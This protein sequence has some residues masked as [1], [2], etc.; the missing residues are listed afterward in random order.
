MESE[1]NYNFNLFRPRNRHGVKN[2]NIILSMLVVWF[3]AVF[4]FQI[5]LKVLEKPVPEKS[6]TAFESAWPAMRSGSA[7]EAEARTCLRSLL[8]VRG[9]ISVNAADQKVLG[10]AITYVTLGLAPDS[11]ARAAIAG[12]AGELISMKSS[13]QGLKDDDFLRMR[14]SITG[15]SRMLADRL[16]Q[17]TGIESGTIES[18]I[19]VSTLLPDFSGSVTGEEFV[20]LDAMMK[21]Y[22]THNQSVLTDTR[23]LGFPFHYFYTAFFL[24]VLFVFLCIL[25]NLRMEMHLKKEGIV[26]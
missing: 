3:V 26:E 23:F 17:F 1:S 9:K 8:L 21:L 19:L 15:K 5:L 24:L 14:E 2:R 4:G 6:L 10:K 7:T 22:L 25:Y 11:S 13:L 20:G 12:S 18:S 16:A